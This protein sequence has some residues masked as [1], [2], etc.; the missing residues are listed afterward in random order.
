M[1]LRMPSVGTNSFQANAGIS[2]SLCS[3]TAGTNAIGS[4]PDMLQGSHMA[5]ELLPGISHEFCENGLFSTDSGDM[6]YG[7]K[8]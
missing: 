3:N 8:V 1:K 4:N 6:S 2:N 7:W 5:T